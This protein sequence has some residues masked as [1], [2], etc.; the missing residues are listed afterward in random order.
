MECPICGLDVDNDMGYCH[1][2]EEITCSIH[3]EE[4]NKD[5]KEE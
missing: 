2:C 4:V 5:S 1:N 3:D